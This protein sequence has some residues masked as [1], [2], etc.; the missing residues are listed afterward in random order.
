MTQNT[1]WFKGLG[2]AAA[3]GGVG[4]WFREGDYLCELICLAQKIS[5][6]PKKRNARLI[7]GEFRVVEVLHAGPTPHRIGE[8]CSIMINLD[9]PYPGLELGKLKGI[10]GAVLGLDIASTEAEWAEVAD[11]ATKPPGTE[12]AG[13]RLVVSGRPTR[14][15]AGQTITALSFSAPPTR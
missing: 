12:L 7:V 3:G 9:G 4:N 10:L 11:K 2:S 15:K 14:T 1:D 6:D 8:T 5:Q 13:H